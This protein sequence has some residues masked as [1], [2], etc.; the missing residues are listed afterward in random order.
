MCLGVTLK[1]LQ[2]IPFEWNLERV[3]IMAFS[4][5]LPN[6]LRFRVLTSLN[7]EKM[8]SASA[9]A[10]SPDQDGRALS[11]GLNFRRAAE[12]LATQTSS[13]SNQC[14]QCFCVELSQERLWSIK[15][16]FRGCGLARY[17]RQKRLRHAKASCPQSFDRYKKKNF[18]APQ[19][20]LQYRED[21]LFPFRPK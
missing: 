2:Q 1:L 18:A 17:M 19:N 10:D 20:S 11:T 15:T 21:S 6:L 7:H 8:R 4:V 13:Q 3:T 5:S 14:H 16:N 12:S 9:F